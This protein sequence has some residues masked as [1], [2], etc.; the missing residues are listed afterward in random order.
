MGTTDTLKLFDDSNSDEDLDGE[1]YEYFDDFISESKDECA[2]DD[3]VDHK[4]WC[5]LNVAY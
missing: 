3:S 1:N 2:A 4:E 5:V